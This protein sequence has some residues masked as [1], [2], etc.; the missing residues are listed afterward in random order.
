MTQ[1]TVIVYPLIV[2]PLIVYPLIVYPLTVYPLIVYPWLFD[3]EPKAKAAMTF[4]FYNTSQLEKVVLWD[5]ILVWSLHATEWW[6]REGNRSVLN[7]SEALTVLCRCHDLAPS[8]V[9]HKSLWVYIYFFCHGS[10][11]TRV[12]GPQVSWLGTSH[13]ASHGSSPGWIGRKRRRL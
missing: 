1:V 2:Y 9:Y 11:L 5:W 12:C 4:D 6:T 10:L 13:G 7:A 8:F 3:S